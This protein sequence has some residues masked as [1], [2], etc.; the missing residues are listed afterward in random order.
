MNFLTVRDCLSKHGHR[1]ADER[2]ERTASLLVDRID[3]QQVRDP[4]LQLVQIELRLF[5]VREVQNEVALI[6][7]QS[8][9]GQDLAIRRVQAKMGD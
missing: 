3:Q 2:K 8:I 5:G 4:R 7:A 1:L 9:T 6:F